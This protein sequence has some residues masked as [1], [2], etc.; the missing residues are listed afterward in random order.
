MPPLAKIIVIAGAV[1]IAFTATTGPAQI[2]NEKCDCSSQ[3]DSSADGNGSKREESQ[4]TSKRKGGKDRSPSRF[5]STR[6]K[7]FPAWARKFALSSGGII[8]GKGTTQIFYS[9]LSEISKLEASSLNIS[10]GDDGSLFIH[11]RYPDSKIVKYSFRVNAHSFAVCPMAKH[12][13]RNAPLGFTIPPYLNEDVLKEGNLLQHKDPAYENHKYI[14]KEFVLDERISELMSASDFWPYFQPNFPVP[15][16]TEVSRETLVELSPELWKEAWLEILPEAWAELPLRLSAETSEEL[17]KGLWKELSPEASEELWKGLW[18]EALEGLSPKAFA[19]LSPEAL[20]EFWKGFSL[21]A[22]EGLSLEAFEELWKGLS[23]EASEELWKGLWQEALEGLSEEALEGLSEELWWAM[24]W[25]NLWA[26]TEEKIWAIALEELSPELW[27][28]AWL[29]FLRTISDELWKVPMN[30]L[31]GAFR[32]NFLKVY[33]EPWSKLWPYFS[34]D[35][36]LIDR[37]IK[38][39]VLE[40]VNSVKVVV[41]GNSRKNNGFTY[42]IGDFHLNTSIVLNSQDRSAVFFGFPLAYF[43]RNDNDLMVVS[44]VKIMAHTPEVPL[45]IDHGRFGPTDFKSLYDLAS[46]FVFFRD[47]APEKL[48]SFIADQCAS[49]AQFRFRIPRRALPHD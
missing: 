25:K 6:S 30:S 20:E 48:S 40:D 36:W 7:T 32:G 23:P 43:Q 12:V 15:L 37:E 22:S 1:A 41:G 17:W 26:K 4:E 3:Q 29:E 27:E 2:I 44:N 35:F 38:K 8:F 13:M 46:T 49:V 24:I 45:A 9:D 19:E 21:E 28:E 10:I 42:I 31:S 14:A 16:S 39:G 33:E 47:N 5:I 34:R 11:V 18:Q